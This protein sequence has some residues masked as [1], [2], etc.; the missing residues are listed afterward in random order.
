MVK[1]FPYITFENTKEAMMYYEK[2]FGATNL[3]RVPLQKEVAVKFYNFS[4]NQI[5]NMTLHGSFSIED[6]VVICSDSFG[7]KTSSD[8]F[9]SILLHFNSEDVIDSNRLINLYNRL[10]ESGEVVVMMPLEEQPSGEKT[11]ILTDKYNITWL[12]HS[13]PYSKMQPLE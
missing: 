10:A 4:E 12:L 8:G 1:L 6:N 9:V 3:I 5:E 11:A 2:V 7:R 13:Q